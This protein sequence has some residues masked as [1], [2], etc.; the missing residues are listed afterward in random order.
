MKTSQ[1]IGNVHSFNTFP[2]GVANDHQSVHMGA[3]KDGE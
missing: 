2:V 1:A 3:G